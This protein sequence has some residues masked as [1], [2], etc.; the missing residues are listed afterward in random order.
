MAIV[1][2][3]PT[4]A[5]PFHRSAPL[6]SR[7]VLDLVHPLALSDR[8][9]SA[10]WSSPIRWMCS[11]RPPTETPDIASDLGMFDQLS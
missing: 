8:E 7:V 11:R 3:C 10:G 4:W 1:M 6:V 9:N 2:L 5:H